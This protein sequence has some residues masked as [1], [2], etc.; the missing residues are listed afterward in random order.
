MANMTET[1]VAVI[2]PTEKEDEFMSAFIGSD[3]YV[4]DR[5][6]YVKAWYVG[7]DEVNSNG[8][9]TYIKFDVECPWTIQRVLE[10]DGDDLC[11]DMLEV[12][13]RCKVEKLV[14][15]SIEPGC[16]LEESCTYE[17]GDNEM[18]YQNRE[19]YPEAWLSLEDY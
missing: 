2:L 6:K 8:V 10:R 12:C 4:K 1:E 19:M 15:H 11:T 17:E 7:T 14:M 18:Y 16:Q 3:T 9:R 13:K 5:S